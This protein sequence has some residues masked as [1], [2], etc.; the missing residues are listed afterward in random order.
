MTIIIFLIILGLLVLV[1]ELGHFLFAKKAG[2]FVE[3][4]GFGYPPRAFVFGKKWGT[5]FTL[6]WVPFGGFVKIFGENYEEEEKESNPQENVSR[7]VIGSTQDPTNVF[8]KQSSVDLKS[9]V[10]L[11]KK[12]QALILF[13][14][15]L[16]NILFAWLLFSL[17][18][19]V[20]L[21]TNSENNFGKE[22]K[23]PAVTILSIVSDSP[24]EEVGLKTGDKILAVSDRNESLQEV[25]IENIREFINKSEDSLNFEIKRGGEKLNFE[26]TPSGSIVDG[27]KLI[28]INMDIVGTISL[29]VHEALYEGA[30]TTFDII[31]QTIIGIF[32]LIKDSF[33][34][35]ADMSQV[36]G[37]IGIIGLVGDAS[38]LGFSYLITFTA[39]ISINLAIINAIPFPALDGGR[40][41]FVAIE[42]VS[43][44]KINKNFAQIVNTIG[45]FI[46]IALM[47]LVTYKD[48]H[49]L[50]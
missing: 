23:D 42:T 5:L 7:K 47:L 13:G 22:I 17:G 3:E 25:N 16:F 1:H 20:G 21:P 50:F 18:F 6:N 43:G 36:A 35:K 34:G 11:S 40:L 30:K 39:L 8:L 46:L 32:S 49:R 24:A 45:F 10:Q 38:R 27:K 28:G 48:I 2:V 4:F 37:P 33:S 12:W 26:I 29:P 41:L 15:I 44:K 14:G 9:F 31:K 19:I